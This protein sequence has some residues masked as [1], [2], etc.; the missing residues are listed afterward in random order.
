MS[1]IPRR[2]NIKSTLSFDQERRKRETKQQ[3]LRKQKKNEIL[4]KRRKEGTEQGKQI[5]PLTQEKVRNNVKLWQ[6]YSF[7]SSRYLFV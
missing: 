5:D 2:E 4:S 6:L 7:S 3:T 1:T